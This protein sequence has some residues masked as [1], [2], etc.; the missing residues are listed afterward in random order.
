[1]RSLHIR[2]AVG[3][4]SFVNHMTRGQGSPGTLE[5]VLSPL[6]I[7]FPIVVPENNP[8]IAVLA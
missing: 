7:G 1:M 8:I 5:L 4:G 3:H 2:G 6:R